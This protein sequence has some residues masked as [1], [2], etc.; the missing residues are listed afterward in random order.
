MGHPSID[1]VFLHLLLS[2]RSSH[3][4]DFQGACDM[5][6]VTAPHFSPNTALTI[7]VRTKVRFWYSYIEAA[8]IQLGDDILEVSAYGLYTLNGVGLEDLN[9]RGED[10]ELPLMA[11]KYA[12]TH[13]QVNKKL[14]K[15]TIHLGE[16]EWIHLHTFKDML[17]VTIEDAHQERF[18]GSGGLM[19]NF[20]TG[21]VMSR[22]GKEILEEPAARAREWQVRDDE[23]MLFQSVQHP[24][25]PS[26]C[27]MPEKKQPVGRLGGSFAKVTAEKACAHWSAQ[28]REFC[29]KDVMQTGDI[30]FAQEAM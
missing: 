30:D 21:Q 26:T 17:S 10:V 23:P 3:R 28:T 1:S 12:V 2:I 29:I 11:G 7:D 18:V 22:S 15:Y 14:H 20:H 4:Y 24:Q 13:T 16:N 19:G 8:A 9:G 5:H 6:L 27:T 25:F